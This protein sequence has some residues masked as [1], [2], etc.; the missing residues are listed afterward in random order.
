MKAGRHLFLDLEDTVITPVVGGWTSWEPINLAKVRAFIE[1]WGPDSVNIFSFALHDAED[2][3]GF[4][5]YVRPFLERELGVRF[6]SVPTTEG[7]ILGACCQ[8]MRLHRGK[9]DFEE[10][11]AFWSKHEAFRLFI[12]SLVGSGVV[13][14]AEVA[15]LD[16]AVADEAFSWPALR[17]GGTIINIDSVGGCGRVAH[18][19]PSDSSSVVM[20]GPSHG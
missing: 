13:G 5:E 12:R 18:A 9:V 10:M 4:D 11:S 15:L 17:V 3:A 7:D 8:V 19:S 20:V 1:W 2:M 6:E 16:D 14:G